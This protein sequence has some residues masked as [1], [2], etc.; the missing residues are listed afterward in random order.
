METKGVEAAGE[1][2]GIDRPARRT[3]LVKAASKIF[4]DRRARSHFISA[5]VFG[6]PAWDMLVALYIT[7][8][9]PAQ[10]AIACLT[11]MVGASPATASRWIDYL[12]QQRLVILEGSSDDP[13]QVFVSLTDAAREA[14][15]AYFSHLSMKRL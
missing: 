2:G 6:E 15:D 13:R 11:Q 4:L 14:L 3:V 9:S 5:A 1:P 10:K 8:E 12:E 7:E